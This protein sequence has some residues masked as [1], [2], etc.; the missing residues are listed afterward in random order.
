MKRATA[1]PAYHDLQDFEPPDGVTEVEIDP[2]DAA[3]GHAGLPRVPQRGF[4]HGT[5]PTE[6]C[7]Q[8]GGSLLTQTP[9]ASWLS[10]LFG[11]RQARR[12][13]N[14]D[15][16]EAADPAFSTGG[17]RGPETCEFREGST[18]QQEPEKKPG[19]FRRIFGIF[20]G[21]KTDQE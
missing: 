2:R 14:A 10:H 13:A 21:S 9:P 15:E 3:T 19:L 8:H 16:P 7:E 18:A 4:Y 20:G 11:G 6:F 5:E 17:T 12:I 1:L